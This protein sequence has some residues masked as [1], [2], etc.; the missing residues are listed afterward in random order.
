[1]IIVW[2]SEEGERPSCL[3]R[4]STVQGMGGA[5]V[6]MRLNMSHLSI[7]PDEKGQTT[8]DAMIMDG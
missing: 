7:S 4:S 5:R 6:V 8:L 1:M 3:L 2:G